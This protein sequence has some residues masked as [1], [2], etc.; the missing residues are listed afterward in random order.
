[1]PSPLAE[2]CFETTD[3]SVPGLRSAARNAKRVGCAALVVAR[4]VDPSDPTI[5]GAPCTVPQLRPNTLQ[6]IAGEVGIPVCARLILSGLRSQEE[7]ERLLQ[8]PATKG[9]TLV[10]VDLDSDPEMLETI[11]LSHSAVDILSVTGCADHVRMPRKRVPS[12][13]VIELSASKIAKFA[14]PATTQRMIAAWVQGACDFAAYPII[15]SGGAHWVRSPGDVSEPPEVNLSFRS[16]KDAAALVDLV[17]ARA[18]RVALE[19]AKLTRKCIALHPVAA[20]RTNAK[21]AANKAADKAGARNTKA[22]RSEDVDA[23]AAK[24]ADDDADVL[25]EEDVP[26]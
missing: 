13:V 24:A 17:T 8:D 7:A 10:S 4:R 22:H 16:P 12:G 23:V 15:A 26:P 3:W 20:H 5:G 1:M 2:L 6:R 21:T 18:G 25:W 11:D 19:T 9:Y 14:A